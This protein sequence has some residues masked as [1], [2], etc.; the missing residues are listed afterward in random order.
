MTNQEANGATNIT[1][2]GQSEGEKNLLKGLH[3]ELQRRRNS[4]ARFLQNKLHQLPPAIRRLMHVLNR[5][6]F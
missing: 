4:G 3:A 6:T 2:V 5:D 1:L